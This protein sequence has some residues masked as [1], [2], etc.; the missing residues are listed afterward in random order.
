MQIVMSPEGYIGTCHAYCG[1]KEYFVRYDPAIDPNQH[2]FWRE[3]RRRSPINMEGCY[4]CIA[5]ANCGGG[6][7]HNAALVAGSI[8]GKGYFFFVHT[9]LKPLRFL[10]EDLYRIRSE[11]QP[12]S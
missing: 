11:S 9:L 3:W 6:C 5:L 10:I 7:P 2:P 8:L 1:T 12:S 4:D